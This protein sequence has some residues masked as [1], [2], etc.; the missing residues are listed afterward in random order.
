[1]TRASNHDLREPVADGG[2][3]ARL[4]TMEDWYQAFLAGSDREQTLI[5]EYRPHAAFLAALRGRVLDVGGGAGVAARFLD[6]SID[7]VVVDPL[8]SWQ[9][10]AWQG[11]SAAF[12]NGGPQPEFVT[13]CGEELPFRDGT[14]DAAVAMWSLNHVRDPERCVL[15]I[16]RVLKPGGLA[17]LVLEDTEPRWTD[18][19]A[20]AGWRLVGR[21]AGRRSRARIA[22]PL[23][24]AVRMKLEGR[25][26]VEEDHA[27]V[28][29]ADLRGW[30]AQAGRIRQRRWLDGYLTLDLERSAVLSKRS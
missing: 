4:S 6:P 13:A 27:P 8:Q 25:W 28:A 7:Y 18:L 2:Y 22:A 10:E 20:E 19:L 30:I 26:E 1:M 14:F 11:F 16:L 9:S 15:E 17:R 5:E 29:E 12:R 23:P 3:E 24:K 21:L